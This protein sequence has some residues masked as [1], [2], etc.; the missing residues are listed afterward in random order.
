MIL[1]AVLHSVKVCNATD[2]FYYHQVNHNLQN[3]NSNAMHLS[4]TSKRE[5]LQ[6]DVAV[7]Q[8]RQQH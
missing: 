3:A 8:Q 4:K 2:Y 5:N 6:I 7:Q 1:E